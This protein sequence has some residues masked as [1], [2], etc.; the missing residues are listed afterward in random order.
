MSPMSRNLAV[1]AALLTMGAGSALAQ[2]SGS[3]SGTAPDQT[4]GAGTPP[5]SA[6]TPTVTGTRRPGVPEVTREGGTGTLG[7]S[8][9]PTVTGTN[10]PGRPALQRNDGAGPPPTR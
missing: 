10:D 1:V 9:P 2:G 6:G 3:R 7:G 8:V 5:T 4:T